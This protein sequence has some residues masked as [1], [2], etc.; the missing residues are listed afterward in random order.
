MGSECSED[1]FVSRS[2][3]LYYHS[4]GC[5]LQHPP[6]TFTL[7]RVGYGWGGDRGLGES[8]GSE[9]IDR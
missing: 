9:R 3:P 1:P 6:P 2:T 8:G 4:F 5:P 7:H